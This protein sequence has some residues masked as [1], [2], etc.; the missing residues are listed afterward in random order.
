M[1][2][3]EK[4][5]QCTEHFLSNLN[6]ETQKYLSCHVCREEGRIPFLSLSL[7]NTGAVQGVKRYSMWNQSDKN[8]TNFLLDKENKQSECFKT[9][10]SEFRLPEGQSADLFPTNCAVGAFNADHPLNLAHSKK[11]SADAD[12]DYLKATAICL[13]CKPGYRPVRNAFFQMVR[14]CELIENCKLAGNASFSQ[15]DECLQSF[16]FK[17]SSS[18]LKGGVDKSHC[19][20]AENNHDQHCYA[21]DENAGKCHTCRSGYSKNHDGR[22]EKLSTAFCEANFNFNR[23]FTKNEFNLAYY[24]GEQGC[25]K[26][27]EGY[28]RIFRQENDFVC[29]SSSYQLNLPEQTN[30]LPHC[31]FYKN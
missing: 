12:F 13:E 25:T 9:D 28:E 14:A 11:N 4:H 23:S 18:K 29:F 16:Y 3:C 27:Q 7:T 24:R 17:Y 8:L 6:V 20:Q 19:F 31:E 1:R 5:H 22:C 2:S 30:Y 26:C 15:C 21:F 10:F